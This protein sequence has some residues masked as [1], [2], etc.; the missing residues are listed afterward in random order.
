MCVC[1]WLSICCLR[2]YLALRQLMGGAGLCCLLLPYV[3]VLWAA[4]D[5]AVLPNHH[6]SHYEQKYAHVDTGHL[7]LERKLLQTEIASN[8]LYTDL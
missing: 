6:R 4:G 1:G 2:V 5:Q 3:P 7:S 8:D